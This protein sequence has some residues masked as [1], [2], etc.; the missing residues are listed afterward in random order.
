MKPYFNKKAL[1]IFL[2]SLVLI[3][4]LLPLGIYYYAVIEHAINI[5]KGEDYQAILESFKEFLNKSSS[6]EGLK[7]LF[8]FY[9]EDRILFVQVSSLLSYYAIGEINLKFLTIWGNIG[10]L[11]ILWILFRSLEIENKTLLYFIP[12]PYLL[13]NPIYYDLS[14]W[15]LASMQ[16]IFS[17]LFSFISLYT[18]KKKNVV[19]FVTAFTF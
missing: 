16:I 18:L 5:P 4:I 6:L 10:L 13:L 7:H 3:I 2:S 14:L 9:N 12:V 15:A 1:P 19:S 17:L 8:G 11:G